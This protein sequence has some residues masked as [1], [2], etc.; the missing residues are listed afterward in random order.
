MHSEFRP[1]PVPDGVVEVHGK[2]YMPDGRGRLTAVEMIRA[3]DRL[4][5][6]IVRREFGWAFALADQIRRFKGHSYTNLAEFD[7]LL[8]QEYGARKGGAKGNR[9]YST[10]DGLMKVEVRI[11]DRFVIG[12]SMAQAKS[13]FDDIL[14]ELAADTA[15]EIRTL[16]TNA[17]STDKEGQI[18]RANLFLLLRTESDNP[19]WC[20]GQR[21]IRDAIRFEGTTSYLRFTFR[22]DF[23]EPEQVVTI[24]LAKA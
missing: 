7:A 11:Q 16:I 19:R 1:H 3:Q 20:D 6:E 10:F 15:P 14:T 18:N 8:E 24:N 4:E 22:A 13:I 23:G 5:D 17:F 9:T 2:K 12:S 21:A